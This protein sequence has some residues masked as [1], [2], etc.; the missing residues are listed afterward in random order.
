MLRITF[1]S[2]RII[3]YCFIATIPVLLCIVIVASK[4]AAARRVRWEF[5]GSNLNNRNPSTPASYRRSRRK[6]LSRSA[7]DEIPM[8]R[9]RSFPSSGTRSSTPDVERGIAYQQTS[10]SHSS[11]TFSP[12][13]ANQTLSRLDSL[14]GG[15]IS[16]SIINMI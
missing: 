9:T 13:L 8:Y 3:G 15:S 4:L 6:T 12:E 7:L 2:G 16:H 11:R 5:S 10:S 14:V 1:P